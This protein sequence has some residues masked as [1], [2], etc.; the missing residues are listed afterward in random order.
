MH[1]EKNNKKD[2]AASE[3]LQ[4]QNGL[5]WQGKLFF[6]GLAAHIASL[7]AAELLGDKDGTLK[8]K[9][10]P[11]RLKG[12]PEQIQAIVDIIT[13]SKEFQK[14]LMKK[15]ASVE[16]VMEKL[17]IQNLTKDKFEKVF[18]KKWPLG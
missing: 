12:K 3:K 8:K 16:S 10:F 9:K 6:A 2:L 7:V 5:T 17:D 18:G 1:K 11:Y 15:G 14:E 4:E 13:S